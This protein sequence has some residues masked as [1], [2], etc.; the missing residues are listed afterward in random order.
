[1]TEILVLRDDELASASDEELRAHYTAL[2]QQYHEFIGA[3]VPKPS[4][5]ETVRSFAN[6][7]GC[8]P[9]QVTFIPAAEASP[10]PH[11]FRPLTPAEFKKV[12]SGPVGEF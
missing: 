8:R 10:Q 4:G 3:E 11:L 6:Y 1:M 7:A 2:A 12:S 5:E 9:D